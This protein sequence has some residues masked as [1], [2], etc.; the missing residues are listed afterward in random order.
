MF[1]KGKMTV[2]ALFLA[3]LMFPRPAKSDPAIIREAVKWVLKALDLQVQREQL[4]TILLQNA[5]KI[6]ENKLT[7]LRLGEITDWSDKRHNLYRDYYD[8]LWRVKSV[9]AQ[10][11]RIRDIAQNQARLVTEYQQA[12]NTIQQGQGFTPDE[13]QYIGRVYAGMLDASMKNMERI[14]SVVGSYRSRMSDAE[15][16]S[17]IHSVDMAVRENLRD[18]RQFNLQNLRMA[19]QRGSYGK[20]AG[21]LKNIHGIP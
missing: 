17:V 19:A 4:Y 6:L 10:Y 1:K 11:K 2:L 13:L 15:R 3:L 5:Q 18:L 8:E 20:D 21:T 14:I 12:W 7:E 9:I 16:L